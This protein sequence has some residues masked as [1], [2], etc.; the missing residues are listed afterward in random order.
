MAADIF[1]S[2]DLSSLLQVCQWVGDAQG[3]YFRAPTNIAPSSMATISV[4][5]EE[6]TRSS[7]LRHRNLLFQH[8]WYKKDQ[9]HFV[10]VRKES[11]VPLALIHRGD[12][13]I[14]QDA[15][16]QQEKVTDEVAETIE[17]HAYMFY[18]PF[19]FHP[20]SFMETFSFAL[21]SVHED[22]ARMGV[23][24]LLAGLLGLLLP[25]VSGWITSMVIPESD[26]H[27]HIQ[28][29]IGLAFAALGS[30]TFKFVQAMAT[31]RIRGR[32]S[33]DIQAALWDRLVALPPSFFRRFSAGELSER[34]M[35]IEQI[36]QMVSGQMLGHILTLVMS[37]MNLF[38]LFYYSWQLAIMAFTMV[39]IMIVIG[40]FIS[41][42]QMNTYKASVAHQCKMTGTVL[43]L[44][45]GLDKIRVAGAEKRA[46]AHWAR[47]FS[48]IRDIRFRASGWSN[49][50]TVFMQ[51][52][53]LLS[54]FCVFTT[55]MVGQF[56]LTMPLGHF[57]AF[58]VSFGQFISSAVQLST[59]L[60]PLMMILPLFQHANMILKARP[61]IKANS[62]EAEPLT[63]E[64]SI[65]RVNFRYRQDSPLVIKDLSLNIKPGEFI[66]LV[67]PSGSGKST[68]MRLLL[69]FEEMS[70]GEIYYNN[71]A[72]SQLDI[73][74]VRRQLGVVL[75]D[76]DVMQGDVF[77]NIVGTS[78][79]TVEN[80]WHV[81]ELAGIANDI[82]EMPMQ[83]NTVLSHG[84]GTLSGGQKQRI[85]IARALIANPR[86][87]IFDEATSALDNTNQKLIQNNI[88][89]MKL[90]RIVVAHRLST[91]IHADRIIVMDKGQIADEGSYDE[92]M[93]RE[94]LFQQMAKRQ[95]L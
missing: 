81:A 66:A 92:L 54:T 16:G 40:S 82:R 85:L 51:S 76:G 58:N 91:V 88:D 68:L 94:G 10:G 34:A 48:T 47:F 55:L 62:K 78:H 74:S 20:M 72:L 44:I 4:A 50:L 43:Q 80:A 30:A 84:G 14:C 69:G 64:I 70:A 79:K 32:S 33:S 61:E 11:G 65:Q 59:S 36:T 86:I 1:K 5:I 53:P 28:L 39:L 42:K 56:F 25:I 22:I 21:K 35:L 8:D 45:T 2:W 90:T 67:G 95:M 52:L 87:L 19:P 9:G 37:V 24:G 75:Q 71:Q 57:I 7:H 83:M 15:S 41:I 3:I 26:L 46:F 6:I 17:N 93:A 49:A 29:C 89:Q 18:R 60:A 38:L 13:Y 23:M 31:L 12:H 73:T 27:M 77:S 63:G